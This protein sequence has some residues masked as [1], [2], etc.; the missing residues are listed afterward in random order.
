MLYYQKRTQYYCG[1]LKNME[2]T[3]FYYAQSYCNFAIARNSFTKHHSF[4]T[5]LGFTVPHIGFVEKGSA[6]FDFGNF[7]LTAYEGDVIFIPTNVPYRSEWLGSPDIDMYAAEVD[8]QELSELSIP[9]QILHLPELAESFS[10]MHR[11]AASGNMLSGMSEMY[12]ILAHMHTRLYVEIKRRDAVCTAAIRYIE[13]N[14][15]EDFS[16]ADL[17]KLCNLSESRF[18]TLFKKESGYSPIDYKNFIRAKYAS[19][20]IRRDGMSTEEICE[21]LG[22]SSTAYFRRVLKKFTGKT[23]TQISREHEM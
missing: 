18:F 19:A 21:R 6:E 23:P 20:Y 11:A 7:K 10:D 4:E 15:A 16:V 2:N 3:R 22:F 9:A 14:C 8:I 13:K 12:R 17:A 1:G 5:K